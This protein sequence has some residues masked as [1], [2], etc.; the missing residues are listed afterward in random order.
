MLLAAAC[1]PVLVLPAP[2]LA[3]TLIDHVE[4]LS[5]TRDGTAERFTGFVIGNDGHI[6]QV[7]RAGD[8]RPARVDYLLDLKGRV[9]LPGLVDGHAKVLELGLTALTL[10]LTPAKSLAE[11][12]ARIAAY[13]AAHPDRAWIIGRGWDSARWGQE[14][15]PTAADLDA[16]VADRPVWLISADGHAG[17]ANSA[18]LRAAAITAPTKDPQGGRIERAAPGAKPTGAL[19]ETALAL[20]DKAVPAPRPEDRDLAFATAQDLILAKG[21]TAV[22]DFG[23]TMEDWQSYRRAGDAGTLRLR[24]IGYAEGTDAMSLIGGPGPTPWLYNDHL[25]LSGVALT[26]DGG[27][28]TRGAWLKAPYAPTATAAPTVTGLPRLNPTQLRNLM[29]RAGIDRFQVAVEANGDAAA[30]AALDAVS[31]LSETYKG[32]RR[33]RIEGLERLDPADAARLPAKGVLPGLRPGDASPRAA[34]TWPAAS[35]VKN[36]ASLTFG[37]GASSGSPS[38]FAAVAAAAAHAEAEQ[39]TREQA[40]AAFTAGSAYAAFAESKFGR[41]AVGQQADFIVVDRDPLLAGTAELAETKVLETWVGGRK[42][43]SAPHQ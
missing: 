22:T 2:V 28:S 31:E 8:K 10:D 30:A 18:A 26:L 6:A 32:D 43:W 35:L 29:S 23:T 39:V 13:A 40:L 27:L 9:V 14:A 17:W 11:A 33:W 38:P 21:I 12:K 4:G 3:D 37:T 36:G 1:P 19:T 41:I 24:V 16:V 42:V 25:R 5:F 20:V 15:L 7:L 34:S